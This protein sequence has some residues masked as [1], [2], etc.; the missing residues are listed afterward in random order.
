MR[1]Q[2]GESIRFEDLLTSYWA[3]SDSI[4]KPLGLML[5]EEQWRVASESPINE[6]RGEKA[7]EYEEWSKQ[8]KDFFWEVCGEEMTL[9]GYST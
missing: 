6:T 8:D 4:L 7:A 1:E 9:Y 2:I 5:S 3:F